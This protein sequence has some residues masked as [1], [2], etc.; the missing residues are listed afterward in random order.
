VTCEDAGVPDFGRST[1][2][3][4]NCVRVERKFEYSCLQLGR[5]IWGDAYLALALGGHIEQMS[6]HETQHV[7]E[8]QGLHLM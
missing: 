8:M 5:A 4:D 7:L 1:S 6:V 3:S 2:D